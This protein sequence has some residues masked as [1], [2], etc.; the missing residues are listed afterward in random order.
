MGR[1][2][3][4]KQEQF[5]QEYVVN[6]GNGSQAVMKVYQTHKPDSAK[7][8]ASNNLTN[9]SIAARIK[10]L[11]QSIVEQSLV[12]IAKGSMHK[13]ICHATRIL[14]H[15]EDCPGYV[16]RMVTNKAGVEVTK[17]VNCARCEEAV[18]ARKFVLEVA[19]SFEVVGDR[20]TN[21]NHLHV[22]GI[23]P[24]GEVVRITGVDQITEA[25]PVDDGPI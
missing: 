23:L 14:A 18:E 15:T 9:P 13:A 8:I 2:L 17:R 4:Y 22:N 6:K 7:V 5:C 19:S 21:H 24:V 1:N 11:S 25:T 16:E 20:D 10:E 12:E 3:T